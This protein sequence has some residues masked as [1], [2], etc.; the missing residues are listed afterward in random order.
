MINKILITVDLIFSFDPTNCFKISIQVGDTDLFQ[1]L[2]QVN[3][4]YTVFKYLFSG[5]N[6]FF[7]FV[8]IKISFNLLLLLRMGFFSFLALN[9]LNFFPVNQR[10]YFDSWE[11]GFQRS[12]KLF[13]LF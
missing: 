9:C 10:P 8:R 7:F 2:S 3:Y 11:I 5:G 4:D 1:N 6:C 13:G 12:N